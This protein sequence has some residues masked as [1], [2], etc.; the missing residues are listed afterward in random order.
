[1]IKKKKITI[2]NFKMRVSSSDVTICIPVARTN[3]IQGT[4][5][6]LRG[7]AGFDGMKALA[8]KSVR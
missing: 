7:C 3:G 8:G 4:Y 6:Y 2:E 1:M 5:N